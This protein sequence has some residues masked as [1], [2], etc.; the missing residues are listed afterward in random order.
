MEGKAKVVVYIDGKEEKVLEGACVFLVV[1]D[2]DAERDGVHNESV[3]FANANA[4]TIGRAIAE[5]EEK[6][7]EIKEE[8]PSIAL[9]ALAWKSQLAEKRCDELFKEFNEILAGG[10]DE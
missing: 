7:R 4:Q 5:M 9:N 3:V 2:Y 1:T 6:I 10:D 8:N